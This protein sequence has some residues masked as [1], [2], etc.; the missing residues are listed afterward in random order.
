MA[1]INA[2]GYSRQAGSAQFGQAVKSQQVWNATAQA[3]GDKVLIGRLLAG[4]RID[5]AATELIFDGATGAMTVDVCVGD[6]ANKVF[7][8]VAILANTFGRSASTAYELALTL[9]VDY[10]QDRDVYLLLEVA[11]TVAGGRV[12]VDLAQIP[13]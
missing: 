13:G 5:A 9:G 8:S 7:D 10:S 1:T 2:A 3:N 4:H 6:D 12:I 11:P